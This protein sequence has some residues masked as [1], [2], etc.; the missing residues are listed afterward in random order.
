MAA[1]LFF[2]TVFIRNNGER[3]GPADPVF[4]WI[5]MKVAVAEVSI[6]ESEKGERG[7]EGGG[8]LGPSE[9]KKQTDGDG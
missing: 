4:G 2:S 9:K 6:T 3:L 1:W 7:G 8:R 5:K